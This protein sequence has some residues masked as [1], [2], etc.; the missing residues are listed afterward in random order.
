M[1]LYVSRSIANMGEGDHSVKFFDMTE[2]TADQMGFVKK[3]K[4]N[5]WGWFE[6]V[7]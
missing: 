4:M 3:L 1:G 2:R 5:G 6:I 7:F